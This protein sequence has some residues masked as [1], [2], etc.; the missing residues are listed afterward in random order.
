[1][2][3]MERLIYE[4]ERG[5][6]HETLFLWAMPDL[7]D[8]C[9][10]RS[11]EERAGKAFHGSLDAAEALHEALLPGWRW[12]TGINGTVFCS[13]AQVWKYG[14]DKAFSASDDNPARAWLLCILKAKA[15]HE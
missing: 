15:A 12:E 6:Y 5:E 8:G 10:A 2:T 11:L 13:V 14:R 3:D 9:L 7:K 4:V 1:M